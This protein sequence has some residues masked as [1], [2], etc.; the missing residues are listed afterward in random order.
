MQSLRNT[1]CG[2]T[3][4][5]NVNTGVASKQL[6]WQLFKFGLPFVLYLIFFLHQTVLYT[7]GV[8]FDFASY[9]SIVIDVGSA[10]AFWYTFLPPTKWLW[11]ICS[12]SPAKRNGRPKHKIA[13]I[14]TSHLDVHQGEI[15]LF[16]HWSCVLNSW[17][18]EVYNILW[19]ALSGRTQTR[20]WMIA[21][22][23]STNSNVNEC[24]A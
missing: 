22:F 4:H 9:K 15:Q 12:K 6:E 5:K 16:K 11:K 13:F 3:V 1:S 23:V 17:W 14:I 24:K 8:L 21:C 19:E 18:T 20:D 2:I 7:A 10:K